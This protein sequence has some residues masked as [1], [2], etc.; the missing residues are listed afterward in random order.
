LPTVHQVVNKCN[1]TKFQ[2]FSGGLSSTTKPPV[3]SS[4]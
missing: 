3:W 1:G 4:A 2:V